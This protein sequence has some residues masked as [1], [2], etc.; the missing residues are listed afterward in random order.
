MNKFVVF[1]YDDHL[2]EV[3]N[4]IDKNIEDSI[5]DL[6][7][8]KGWGSC[9]S[10][11]QIGDEL[12]R[13]K[14]SINEISKECNSIWIVESYYDL[15]FFVHILPV[16]I[17]AKEKRWLVYYGRNFSK[18][19]E[20]L[21]RKIIDEKYLI[22]LKQEYENNDVQNRL[23]DIKKPVIWIVDMFSG[24]PYKNTLFMLYDSFQ[25]LGYSVNAITKRKDVPLLFEEIKVFPNMLGLNIQESV[26]NI[27]HYL[28]EI[29]RHESRD[30][31]LIR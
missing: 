27:N 15:D 13:V 14:S 21:I 22:V 30:L 3:I 6:L 5:E 2:T 9:G 4:W 31:F 7:T 1:P 23:Y 16:L 19:E 18:E 10:Q 28:K 17:Y 20:G 26:K 12:V 11:V 25:Q 24:M 29:E 8:M